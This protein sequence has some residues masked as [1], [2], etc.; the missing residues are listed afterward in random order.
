MA[1]SNVQLML[2]KDV[3]KL[4]KLGELVNVAPGYAQNYLLPNGMAVRA[5]VGITKEVERRKEKE[6]QRLIAIREEAEARKAT[7]SV[8][9]NLIIKK[10]V[11]ENNSIF[12]SVTD[13]EVAQLI[14]AK[15]TLEI[16]RREITVP[17]IKQIGTYDV[18][19]KLHAEV[20]ATVTVQVVPE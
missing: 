20:T 2:I 18:D 11:G 6:R 14:L 8:I 9:G 17:D 13:R 16:D 10:A 5:T 19:I 15:S 3:V 4:G 12:G 7:L 1:K